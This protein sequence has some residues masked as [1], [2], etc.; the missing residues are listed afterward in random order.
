MTSLVK[1]LCP[2][3]GEKNGVPAFINL[4]KAKLKVLYVTVC[5]C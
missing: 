4:V 2:H 3:K 5:E 1:K